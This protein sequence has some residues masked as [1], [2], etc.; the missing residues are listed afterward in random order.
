MV[1]DFFFESSVIKNICTCQPSEEIIN[2]VLKNNT[3]I[4]KQ[5]VR[6]TQHK[7]ALKLQYAK[8]FLSY[9]TCVAVH[10]QLNHLVR[11]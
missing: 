10:K 6:E 11:K 4:M 5:I 8:R 7:M 9:C 3:S 2:T 1:I